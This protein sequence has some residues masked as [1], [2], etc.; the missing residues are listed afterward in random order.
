[1]LPLPPATTFATV[2]A[3][4]LKSAPHRLHYQQSP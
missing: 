4:V 3:T 2:S 1:L